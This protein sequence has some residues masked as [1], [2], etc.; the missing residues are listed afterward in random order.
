ME[1][2]FATERAWNGRANQVQGLN[3]FGNIC[4]NVD[5]A[6]R[7]AEREWG[8]KMGHRASCCS[9]DDAEFTPRLPKSRDAG[10]GSTPSSYRRQTQAWLFGVRCR[11]I[12]P[13]GYVNWVVW[14]LNTNNWHFFAFLQF[15]FRRTD[16]LHLLQHSHGSLLGKSEPLGT[17]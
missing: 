13:A 6:R 9:G 8:P 7:K 10:S 14:W 2:R 17:N 16:N 15:D 12:R 3:P 1:E 11:S 5:D 4:A